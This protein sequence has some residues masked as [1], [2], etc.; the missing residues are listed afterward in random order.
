MI[1]WIKKWKN[2]KITD[3]LV[4]DGNW[5]TSRKKMEGNTILPKFCHVCPNHDF[6]NFPEVR[7]KFV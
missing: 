5:R 7:K 3:A 1:N 2:S 4:R 6:L